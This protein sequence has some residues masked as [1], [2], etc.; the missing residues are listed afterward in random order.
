MPPPPRLPSHRQPRPRD[1]RAA[2]GLP[3]GTPDSTFRLRSQNLTA[4]VD[5]ALATPKP[6]TDPL[7]SP[8]RPSSC[9]RFQGWGGAQSPSPRLVSQKPPRAASTSL[10]SL[11]PPQPRSDQRN[12]LDTRLPWSPFPGYPHP[13]LAHVPPSPASSAPCSSRSGLHPAGSPAPFGSSL[14]HHLPGGAAA[15]RPFKTASSPCPAS[16]FC[17]ALAPS[18]TH[19]RHLW[20][21]ACLSTMT[22]TF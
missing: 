8:S 16:L 21:N 10:P 22:L 15:P 12:P 1:S 4:S 2:L 13:H 18:N 11:S 19:P 7:A 5:A 3:L 14:R 20:L 6:A 17:I 9:D